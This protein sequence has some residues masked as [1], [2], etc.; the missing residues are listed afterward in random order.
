MLVTDGY[1]LSWSPFRGELDGVTHDQ[2]TASHPLLRTIVLER[3]GLV[4]SR[5]AS[6][7]P[8]SCGAVLGSVYPAS[9]VLKTALDPDARWMV[10][11]ARLKGVRMKGQALWGWGQIEGGLGAGG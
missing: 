1:G 8:V 9:S 7:V 5:Q 11:N 6:R 2:R 3:P 10:E 4:P